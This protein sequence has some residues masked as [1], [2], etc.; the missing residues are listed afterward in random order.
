MA[1]MGLPGVVVDD[2][3]PDIVPGLSAVGII[4]QI[5]IIMLDRSPKTLNKNIVDPA[6]FAVHARLYPVSLHGIQ[7]FV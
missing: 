6:A 4:S 3:L 5:N 1:L 7:P 2:E